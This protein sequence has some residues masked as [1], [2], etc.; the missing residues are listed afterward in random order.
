MW[1]HVIPIK[2][3]CEVLFGY[4]LI[5]KIIDYVLIDYSLIALG[6]ALRANAKSPLA[7]AGAFMASRL[8]A[9]APY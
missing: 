2:T 4:M 6:A 7:M 9:T 1:L 3:R 5:I 8:R